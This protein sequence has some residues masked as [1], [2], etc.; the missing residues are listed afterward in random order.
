MSRQLSARTHGL[1]ETKQKLHK[2]L[3]PATKHG[4]LVPKLYDPMPPIN[5][6]WDD[7]VSKIGV[8]WVNVTCFRMGHQ[9]S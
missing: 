1:A 2:G 4:R 6:L 8:P 3:C 9:P 5:L 7:P